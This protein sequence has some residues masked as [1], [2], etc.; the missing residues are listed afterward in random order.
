MSTIKSIV[1]VHRA[2]WKIFRFIK[3]R[4]VDEARGSRLATVNGGLASRWAISNS[5]ISKNCQILSHYGLLN[6]HKEKYENYKFIH[7]KVLRFI[8][9][10]RLPVFVRANNNNCLIHFSYPDDECAKKEAR[11]ELVSDC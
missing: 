10:T 1:R 4:G 11:W 8:F 3:L 2:E 5:A 6:N 7:K 9:V